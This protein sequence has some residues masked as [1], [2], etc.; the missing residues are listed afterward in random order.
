[1]PSNFQKDDPI[2]GTVDLDDAYITDA[3]LVD[4]FVG[5]QLFTWG[6]NSSGQLGYTIFSAES[7]VQVGSLIN[8]KQIGACKASGA[9]AGC[10]KTDGTLWT[11]GLNS[12]GQLGLSDTTSRSSPVQVGTLTN[13]KQIFAGT[14]HTAC[15]K[16]DGTLWT[17][18]LNSSG[19]LGLSDTTSRSSPVQVGTLTN[20][21]QVSCGGNASFSHTACVKTDGTLWT[22]G[23]NGLG[24]LGLGDTT[25]RSSPVQVGSLTNW[26]QIFVGGWYNA[27]V[28]TDGTLWTWGFNNGNLGL[29]DTT[30]RSSP[31]QVGTLTNWKQVSCGSDAEHTACVKTDGT[32][33]MWGSNSTYGQLGLGD[34]TSRSSPVQVGTLTNWKQVSCGPYHTA[35]VKTDG[36][37]WSWG[38]NTN[39]RLGVGDFTN[40]SSPVQIGSLTNWKQVSCGSDFTGCTTF[41]EIV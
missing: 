39:G 1:M 18:G 36:T 32:L 34:T 26:K 22:W 41:T 20:W 15:V 31:V 16:T 28:K 4:Q 8:W 33:W 17:W 24:Q 7:P 35:C 12:S 14:S 2:F 13:W 23:P 29:G 19:Q 40:R 38:R 21:K 3:W 30:S 6:N 25:S 9:H 5:N 10:V 37:L 27:C 11:W